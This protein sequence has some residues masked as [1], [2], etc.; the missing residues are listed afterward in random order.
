MDA[1][2]LPEFSIVI[3]THNRYDKLRNLISS[4][5]RSKPT[6]LAEVIVVDDSAVKE[7][8]SSWSNTL[9]IRAIN[10]DHRIFISQAKNRGIAETSSEIIFFID[11]DNQVDEST[12]YWP[13]AILKEDASVGAVFP[14]VLYSR[15]RSIVW[16]YATPFKKDR[17]GHELIGRN[18]PRDPSLEN[19]LID[20]DALPNAFAVRKKALQQ[21]GGFNENL[22]VYNSAY[23]A[24]SL[25]LKK[26]RVIAH[27]GSFIFH[28]VELPSNFGYWAE[29]EIPD[30]QRLKIE[31][32]DWMIFMKIVHAG[33]ALFVIRAILKS[34]SYII[35]N[36]LVYLLRGGEMRFTLIKSEIAG[37]IE[38]LKAS[39]RTSI[40][41][42]RI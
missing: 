18:R 40:S 4:L 10:I 2:S 42:P 35:P 39:S 36:S 21:V 32:R 22:P 26:W 34:S 20:I 13:I 17:W 1:G 3:P 41:E 29:H 12:F 33:E 15:D 7:D 9:N 11:D 38:G 27:T 25:K 37:L 23:L 30:A 19:R 8:V 16:V 28:D 5:E 6:N 14:S 31:I 24:L